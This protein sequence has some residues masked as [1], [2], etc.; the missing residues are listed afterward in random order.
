MN[1]AKSFSVVDAIILSHPRWGETSNALVEQSTTLSSKSSNSISLEHKETRF[2][3][4][5]LALL[6]RAPSSN[7]IVRA[8]L[9]LLD[10]DQSKGTSTASTTVQVLLNLA[11]TCDPTS[12]DYAHG[13]D[14]EILSRLFEFW[15]STSGDEFSDVFSQQLYC[16]VRTYFARLLSS[17]LSTDTLEAT[18]LLTLL[19]T[20]SEDVIIDR[21]LGLDHPTSDQHEMQANA[22]VLESILQSDPLR[23]APYFLAKFLEKDFLQSTIWSSGLLDGAVEKLVSHPA[24]RC[25]GPS[26][27]S[28]LGNA[29]LARTSTALEEIQ[30]V[31]QRDGSLDVA[32]TLD[33]ANE[34]LISGMV[35]V[36]VD[37]LANTI[38]E[39]LCI[40][41]KDGKAVKNNVIGDVC[42]VGM[43]LLRREIKD[44][45]PDFTAPWRLSTALF[46]S[47][48]DLLVVSYKTV[49]RGVDAEHSLDCQTIVDF[50]VS[51][52]EREQEIDPNIISQAND[53]VL[54]K[55]CRSGL[56][57]GI[58]DSEGASRRL[59]ASSLKL[60]RL[61][62]A[63]LPRIQTLSAHF[64]AIPELFGM[65][66]SHSKFVAMFSRKR[67]PIVEEDDRIEL[68][69]LMHCCVK[70]SSN[71][72]VVEPELW[73]ILSHAYG[74]G[75]DELDMSIQRFFYL[76]STT[77][78]KKVNVPFLDEFRWSGCAQTQSRE[79]RR[80]DWL[81]DAID[82][83][84][85]RE[86]VAC[87]PTNDTLNL[88]NIDASDHASTAPNG[89]EKD[90]SD[91]S[92]DDDDSDRDET[93]RSEHG[94]VEG[95]FVQPNSTRRD[96]DSRYSPAFILPLVL[97]S[98]H[99]CS[100]KHDD[101]SNTE[102]GQEVNE[103]FRQPP[104][105]MGSSGPLVSTSKILIEKGVAA[106]CL[107]SLASACE[108]IRGLSI[109]ILGI[110]LKACSTDEARTMSSWRER[111]Q[112]AMLLH[113]VQRAYVLERAKQPYGME[114]VNIPRLP[115][116]VS[117]FLARSS[118]SIS[119]PDDSLYVP[120]NRFYLK[121][122]ADH[123]A[124]QDMSRLPSFI[125]L[126][127]SASDD[128]VQSRKERIWAL[129]LIRDGFLDS[130]C[131]RLVSSCHAPELLLSSFE[132][133]R[134]SSFSD[135]MKSTELVLLLDAIKIFLDRGGSSAASHLIGRIGL[136]SWLRSVCTSRVISETFPLENTR[137]V[138]CELIH[139]AVE[140]VSRNG[141]L[142]KPS[143]ID[144]L[145]GLITPT[146]ALC[147]GVEADNNGDSN[148]VV[149]ASVQTLSSLRALLLQL[150]DLEDFEC[151]NIHPAGVRLDEAMRFLKLFPGDSLKG[152]EVFSY[153]PFC[154][155]HQGPSLKSAAATFCTYLLEWGSKSSTS[156]KLTSETAKA[157]LNRVVLIAD[158]LGGDFGPDGANESLTRI[159]LSSRT[160]YQGTEESSL[161]WI[162]CLELLS[163]RL[164]PDGSIVA[165]LSA[166]VLN[167]T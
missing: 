158:R 101:W 116:L 57:Y 118:L 77:E 155:D 16:P 113:A 59:A 55:V 21:C 24:I 19:T 104:R 41:L 141:F 129:Q 31:R 149:E 82:I 96:E 109:S 52:L 1:E 25:M 128:P 164:P 17:V 61:L 120:L 136:L 126:F 58:H 123:G 75:L 84:R 134:L 91:E 71:L 127:C 105:P 32:G 103:N 4:L 6:G 23:F 39:F 56:K 167:Q 5:K 65:L 133:V 3:L 137:V 135:E 97:G 144:E 146:L 114:E 112:I 37:E 36:P 15:W 131:Y 166:D 28:S 18:F 26:S 147:S 49:A 148:R 115:S 94:L 121:S 42:R 122:E 50:L 60:V 132:N 83:N 162:E 86:T 102:D 48:L 51:L 62:L 99:A 150:N 29:V 125:S 7:Q 130:S 47:L 139:S 161:L 145:C 69:R 44:L 22:R 13:Y 81:L 165:Q 154:L 74:A 70:L 66:T 119:R 72:A 88:K 27:L 95:D 152:I 85:I 73:E 153:L 35:V 14:F 151:P 79:G 142:F 64:V 89:E 163:L 90:E 63:R 68:V 98:L 9:M 67:S 76:C 43:T 53:S 2:F 11:T 140:A 34:A 143:L 30:T 160:R 40:T 156:N 100:T 106:L 45:H 108:T 54:Q 138:A 20:K 124:F 157:I 12:T 78:G 33:L 111:P 38:S 46:C 80:W 10:S 92:D 93:G 159:L 117:T 87:F 107:A 110:F 8:Q